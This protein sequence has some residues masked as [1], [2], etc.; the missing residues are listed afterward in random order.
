MLTIGQLAQHIDAAAVL[1]KRQIGD[2]RDKDENTSLEIV[3]WDPGA[4]LERLQDPSS[5]VAHGRLNL[6]LSAMD[7]FPHQREAFADLLNDSTVSLSA[8]RS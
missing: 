1:A 2:A 5:W 7:A 6:L 4:V 3:A 8:R